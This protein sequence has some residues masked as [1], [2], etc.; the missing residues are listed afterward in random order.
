MKPIKNPFIGRDEYACFACSP[1]HP[2]GLKMEFFQ[3]GEEVVCFWEPDSRFE[4]YH[5]VLHGGIQSTLFDEIA[6]WLVFVKLKTAGVTSRLAVEFLRPVHIN[7]GRIRLTA[8]LAET[9]DRTASI[10]C[11][12]FDSRNHLCARAEVEYVTYSRDLAEKKLDYPG[13]ERFFS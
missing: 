6:S 10:H 7:R 8:A 9:R 3:D 4:G 5:D 1:D 13:Y 12:L 2:A 11:Q